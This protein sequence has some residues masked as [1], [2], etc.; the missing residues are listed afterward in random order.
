[1]DAITPFSNQSN[2]SEAN[3]QSKAEKCFRTEVAPLLP[4]PQLKALFLKYHQSE[5]VS[6]VLCPDIDY[7]AM[8][9]EGKEILE[10]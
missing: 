2:E 6:G 4:A 5:N 7:T 9:Q 3:F 1:M 8:Y 10:D